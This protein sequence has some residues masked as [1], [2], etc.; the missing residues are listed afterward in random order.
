[1]KVAEMI[2]HTQNKRRNS[3]PLGLGWTHRMPLRLIGATVM[4][5]L[6]PTIAVATPVEF[7]TLDYPSAG[8]FGGFG[9][10][11]GSTIGETFVAPQGGSVNLKNFSFVG[12][13]YYPAG[14]AAS[15]YMQAFVFSWSGNMIG[16]GG[17]ATGSALY[18][19]P[20]FVY[21]P[22]PYSQGTWAPLAAELGA[23]GVSLK[24]GGHY[25]IGF[26]LSNP[27]NYAASRGD[28]EFQ[29]VST[30][31]PYSNIP[32][33]VDGGGQVVYDNNGNN[34]G[35]LNTVAWDLQG[36]GGDLAFKADFNVPET[37]DSALCVLAAAALIV[38]ARRQKRQKTA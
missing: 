27:S 30:R 37:A 29:L 7:N 14:G 21:S 32:A 15:L 5:S 3:G 33:S 19:G 25:V 1:M 24:P 12:Q 20:T 2:T 11:G 35:A 34:F 31:N 10:D 23:T 36:D 6:L 26:T 28:I 17:G 9:P 8:I 13:S 4:G 38:F 22:P 18:L 16:A